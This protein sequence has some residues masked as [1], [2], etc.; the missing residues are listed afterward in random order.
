MPNPKSAPRVPSYRLH[1]PS[2]QAVV[3]LSGIDIY[4]GRWG[5]RASRAEY[6]RHVGEWLAN[7]RCLPM[8]QAPVTITELAL[9]Y[10][11]FAKRYYRRD[12]RPTDT[13]DRVKTA[14]RVLRQGYGPLPVDRFGPLALKSIEQKLV[15]S[16]LSRPYINCLVQ[17]I[18]RVFKWGVAQE[19]VPEPVYRALTCVPGL[20]KGR[21]SAPEPEPVRPVAAEVEVGLYRLARMAPLP[22]LDSA[23]AP[24]G[25][26]VI[27]R[28]KIA[29]PTGDVSP[30]VVVSAD[31]GPVR[32]IGHDLMRGQAAPGEQLPIALYWRVEEGLGR[33]YQ[34][35]L[36]LVAEDEKIVG[37]GDGPPLGGDYP[38][39]YWEAGETLVDR[40]VVGVQPGAPAGRYD[41]YV[42]LYD[43][44]SGERLPLV[45]P[46]GAP[47]GDRVLLGTLDVTG[48]LARVLRAGAAGRGA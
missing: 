19:I 14:L 46:D 27:A 35:F 33:D 4:L 5:T 15:E 1:K 28:V 26:P 21:T 10:W 2:G 47:V 45:G 48:D 22:V 39:S 3:T 38:T 6:E 17:T 12:G 11:R 32:L 37:Q 25:R 13:I 43:L 44:A 23:G 29:V 36:H 42:G 31:L 8:S 34:V 24:V 9:A 41:V 18:R 40:H 16:H 20:R 30:P 7:G